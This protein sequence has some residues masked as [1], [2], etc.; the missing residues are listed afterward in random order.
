M[1]ED[2]K[3]TPEHYCVKEFLLTSWCAGE[4]TFVSS[5]LFAVTMGSS[6]YNLMASTEMC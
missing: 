1:E 6:T 4:H 2:P 3:H 5:I